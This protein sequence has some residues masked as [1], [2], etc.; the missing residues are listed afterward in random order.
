MMR[1]ERT[2]SENWKRN[3][4]VIWV[5]QFLSIM[6][7]SFG[8]PFAPFFFQELGVTNSSELSMWVALFG[9][10]TP[11]TMAIFSPV[12]GALSDRMGRRPM[13]LRAYLGAAV[14]LSLMGFV[15]SPIWLIVLRLMQGVLTGTVTASQTLV[16][17][18]TPSRHSGMALGAL[19]SAV[20]SG[21]LTGAFLGG[22]TAEFFGYRTAFCLSGSVMV[23]SAAIVFFGVKESFKA[24]PRHPDG[25][26]GGMLSGFKPGAAQIWL[27]LPILLL[28]TAVMFVKQF[29]SSFL[30]LLVQDIN[31]KLEGASLKTGSLLAV[32]GGA[33][34]ISGLTLGWLADR[35]SPA[36]I[37][38]WSALAA[39]ALIIPQ[40]F[41]GCMGMLFG[42]RFGMVF[43]SGGLEPVLQ[44]WLSRMAPE[45][46]R[47]LLFGWSASARSLGWFMAPLAGGAVVSFFGLRWLYIVA[48]FLYL[49]LIPIIAW[50]ARRLRN[51][52]PSDEAEETI[53]VSE[54]T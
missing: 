6:G 12:W 42:L 19:N 30:P 13:L 33:G 4:G 10:S 53:I 38:K 15:T 5:A 39:G 20:F 50:T 8:I 43:A 3:L 23:A 31:G 34:V 46:S 48:G 36:S 14:V 54:K 37:G 45:R 1:E 18:H 47:G 11:L 28:M 9:A 29:D 35:F 51:Q 16:S 24:P 26:L 32:C 44:I 27:V 2:D 22:W 21:A 40:A 52:I 7:F 49:L 17:A 25:L 41:A